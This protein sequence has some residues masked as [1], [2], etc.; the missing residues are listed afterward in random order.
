MCIQVMTLHLVIIF[1]TE[2]QS[3]FPVNY[4]RAKGFF[5]AGLFNCFIFSIERAREFNL[6]CSLLTLLD[7]GDCASFFEYS[8]YI[9]AK[10]GVPWNPGNYS[11][12]ATEGTLLQ[13]LS[14]VDHY[15]RAQCH[16]M[17]LPN[18]HIYQQIIP[19][20]STSS[21]HLVTDST[22]EEHLVHVVDLTATLTRRD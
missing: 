14:P 12:S 6:E 5:V 18:S 19:P 1:T 17:M 4:A 20:L 7:Q 9:I 11:K 15:C 21:H 10:R 16:Q 2:L 3:R 13:Q 8:L 22:H